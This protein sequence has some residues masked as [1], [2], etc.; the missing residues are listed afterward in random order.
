MAQLLCLCHLTHRVLA[1]PH[2]RNPPPHSLILTARGSSPVLCTPTFSAAHRMTRSVG[3]VQTCHA[4]LC[5]MP[6]K[7]LRINR[8]CH[9]PETHGAREQDHTLQ[10]AQQLGRPGSPCAQ[11]PAQRSWLPP[12]HSEPCQHPAQEPCLGP[13]VPAERPRVDTLSAVHAL[14]LPL[15]QGQEAAGAGLCGLCVWFLWRPE[16]SHREGVDHLVRHYCEAE[17]L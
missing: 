7:T 2:T 9:E 13:S 12:P 17:L 5:S 6:H 4:E 16:A 15:A 14:I 3:Q 8:Y 1:S 11:P 10:A